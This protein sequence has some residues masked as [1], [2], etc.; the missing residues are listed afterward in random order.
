MSCRVTLAASAGPSPAWLIT[1]QVQPAKLSAV[2]TSISRTLTL[3]SACKDLKCE[4]FNGGTLRP[5]CLSIKGRGFKRMQIFFYN[6]EDRD[7][8]YML[9]NY[10]AI[11]SSES[12]ASSWKSKVFTKWE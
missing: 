4:K 9:L 3:P 7:E 6:V 2:C 12:I 8:W 11:S 1:I 5:Y 10:D